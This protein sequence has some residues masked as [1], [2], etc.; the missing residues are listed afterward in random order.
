M[1][2]SS[3]RAPYRMLAVSQDA[4][5]APDVLKIIEM[6]RPVPALG[7]ILVRVHAA[8]VNPT[9]WKTRARG[10]F[11]TGALPPFVLG[12]DVSGVVEEVGPG[13]TLF[14][15]GDEVFGMPRFPHPAGAYAEFV[16]APARHFCRKPANIDHTTAAALPLASLT[17]WQALVD[18]ADI[19]PGQRVLVHAA[20]GGVGHLAVQIAKARGA[21]VVGTARAG[22]H[23]LLRGLGADELIDYTTDDFGVVLRDLDVVLDTIGGDYTAR[24][25]RTLRRG[26]ILVSLLPVAPDFP[27]DLAEELGVRATRLL[28]EPDQ[29]G[30]KAVADLVARGQLRPLV[31]TTLPLREAARAH[32]RGE[33]N[34]TT[35]KIVLS[36]IA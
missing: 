33:T 30:M 10:R 25:L 34:S 11:A 13:V 29:A 19:Q 31:D 7:E 14:A 15:A 23:D 17:A 9:D 35:G 26:G 24:S 4:A 5:G 20:A 27:A 28:V 6:A 22:K 32:E 12:F 1:T 3:G 36:V 8:G 16:T 21:W 2:T 18:T